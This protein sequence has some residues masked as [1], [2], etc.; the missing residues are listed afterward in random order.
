VAAELGELPCR[1]V[2]LATAA[3]ADVV[4]T[5][6]PSRTPVVCDENVR[7]GAHINALGADAPGKQE[8]EATILCRGRVFL[9]DDEQARESGEVNVPLHDGRLSPDAIVGTLGEVVAGSL[10]GRT[11][12][13]D[14]TIFDSTG[15]AVQDLAV[16]VLVYARACSQRVGEAV[17]LVAD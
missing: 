15:L 4:C 12:D 1:V 17:A 14:I 16:A 6:T 13:T 5:M 2:D 10:P 8:L 9:D 7:P 3:D 11:S